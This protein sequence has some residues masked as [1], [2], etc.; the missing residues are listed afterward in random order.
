MKT[1]DFA[2][3]YRNITENIPTYIQEV[4][5]STSDKAM[6]LFHLSSSLYGLLYIRWLWLRLKSSKS[7]KSWH[8]TFY[9]KRN[10][11]VGRKWHD[12]RE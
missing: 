7:Q 8:A 3:L 11:Y 9:A 1:L 2:T 12:V 10:A 4:L 6:L 5:A